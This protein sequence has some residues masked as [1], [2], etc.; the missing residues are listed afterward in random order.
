MSS[1]SVVRITGAVLL[2]NSSCIGCRYCRWMCPYD[3]PHFEAAAGVL[4]KCTFCNP[5]FL[6]DRAPACAAACPTGALAVEDR[7]GL[8]EPEFPGR[9]KQGLGRLGHSQGCS[10]RL[11]GSSLKVTSTLPA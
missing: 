8:P 11:R 2:G 9:P 6:E 4:T 1:K 7:M 3:A 5:W 10:T